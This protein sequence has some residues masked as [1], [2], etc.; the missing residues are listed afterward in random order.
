MPCAPTMTA[1][2]PLSIKL[3]STK[4]ARTNSGWAGLNIRLTKMAILNWSMTSRHYGIRQRHQPPTGLAIRAIAKCGVCPHGAKSWRPPLLGAMG[5]KCCRNCRTASE[6]INRLIVADEEST[7][8]RFQE[9]LGGL[10]KN[11]NPCIT[12]AGSRRN[13]L[14]AHHHQTCL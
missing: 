8:K 1:S 14:A 12:E 9:F 4:N 13:A 3:N 2:M 6:R 10:Q 11:I 5:E 7:K